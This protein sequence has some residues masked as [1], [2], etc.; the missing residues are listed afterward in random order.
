[1]SPF[2]NFILNIVKKKPHQCAVP[3]GY[4][5]NTHKDETSLSC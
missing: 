2:L 3:N 4:G 1:M 5:Q